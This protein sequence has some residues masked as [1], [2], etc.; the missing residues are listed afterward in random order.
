MAITLVDATPTGAVQVIQGY[1]PGGFKVS[2]TIHL[3]AILVW[4]EQTLAWPAT[5]LAAA[6]PESFAPLFAAD[7]ALELVL[8]GAGSRFARLPPALAAAL[9]DQGLS[10]EAM[11][12]RAAAR[13]YNVLLGEGRRVAA[14]LL[15]IE[16]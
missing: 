1:V 10:A 15:P 8:V 7:P 13:T 4:P 12:S 2:G 14:A 5:T 9:K 6:T 3:G 16:R 11:D